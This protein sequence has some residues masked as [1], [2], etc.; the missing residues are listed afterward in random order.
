[1]NGRL[2][3]EFTYK[4][5]RSLVDNIE[6]HLKP[7]S[8]RINSRHTYTLQGFVYAFKIWIFETFP[9]SSIVGSPLSGVIPQAVVYARCNM[10]FIK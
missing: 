8:A 4:K 7:N 10:P 3:W 5:L 6:D 1:M 9:N 2:I